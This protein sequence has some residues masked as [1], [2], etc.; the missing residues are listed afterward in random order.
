LFKTFGLA[1]LA[2]VVA[3]VVGFG[4]RG[5]TTPKA[6]ADTTDVV[7][8]ACENIAGLIDG[9]PSNATN[10]GDVQV[11]CGAD[12]LGTH[13]VGYGT[14][15]PAGTSATAG[16]HGT[17]GARSVYSLANAIGNEDGTLEASDF[18]GADHFDEN[19]DQNQI[20]TD[21]TKAAQ[22]IGG[23]FLL[24]VGSSLACTLD[25]FVFVNHDQRIEFDLPTGLK[26]IESQSLATTFGGPVNLDFTCLMDDRSHVGL[27]NE[28]SAVGGGITGSGNV[29]TAIVSTSAAA[30]S[31]ASIVSTAHG[32]VT[33]DTVIV[34]GATDAALNGTWVV[35]V[36]DANTFTIPTISTALGGAV[37]TVTK[38]NGS[39]ITTATAHLLVVG[40][41][42]TISGSSDVALNGQWRVNSVPSAT[43]FTVGN[44]L[45]N[46]GAD[47]IATAVAGG[48]AVATR[49]WA[50]G[51]D[52]DCNG[53]QNTLGIAN[54]GDG[55]AMFH[56]LEDNA[57]AGSVNTVITSQDDVAQSFDVN[58]VGS[59]NQIVLTL[60]EKLIE[61]NKTTANVTACQTDTKVTEGLA[62]PTSTV[63]W[64]VVTDKYN[65]V[66][67]R[68]WVNF[69]VTP[70]ESTEIAKIGLGDGP[71]EI[72]S[73]TNVTLH[74]T[75]A[76]L[77]TA[78]Y[79]V[80]CGGKETG[81]ATID[82]S[83]NLVS[84][85]LTGCTVL[86]SQDRDRQDLTVGG[87]PSGNVL[88]AE[89]SAIKCD[90]TEKSTVTAKVT[91]SAGNDV[92]NGVPVNFSVVALGTANPINTVTQDGKASSVIT[93]L[94]NSSAGTTVIVTAGDSGLA[95]VVQ[96]S[97]RV[98][99]ALPLA[100]QP[101]APAAVP[102]PRGGI[103]GPDTGNGGY[104]GQNGSSGLP[105]WT[106]IALVLGSVALVAGGMVTRRAGK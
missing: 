95:S 29:A 40:D 22:P 94:S 16:K 51:S 57:S 5:T 58:V 102:T 87:V 7:V 49:D 47:R 33:G 2:V 41:V 36:V 106:L 10:E 44:G 81:T 67:T 80:I 39:T 69:K 9:D 59:P 12:A 8:V 63:A 37:G 53:G 24:S 27:A 96:T 74:P 54:N 25:V 4:A 21:C 89:A 34:T 84:C 23:S 28:N 92:A 97:I 3:L 65:T 11:A 45:L 72:T 60:G 43:T 19:W 35:T 93:P 73:N 104:L 70:P 83:I 6:H 86:S 61:T 82:A 90:G 68:I 103:G 14:E 99:C 30:T 50:V 18:R 55:V 78:A 71:E 46:G 88:T 75:T 77:P 62:P 42:V 76:G 105:M 79:T 31:P 85:S 101:L 91:D 20:S 13:V 15:L 64:A 52:N 26:S 100:T 98:D 38:A 48:A 17:P 1:A 66:L 32:L 56:I